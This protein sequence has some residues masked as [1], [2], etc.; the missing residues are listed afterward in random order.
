MTHTP[1]ADRCN[2]P[3]RRLTRD[4]DRRQRTNLPARHRSCVRRSSIDYVAIAQRALRTE[5]QRV[6]HLTCRGRGSGQNTE[7]LL[8]AAR[9]VADL[10]LI[11][12]NGR[13]LITLPDWHGRRGHGE[14]GRPGERKSD[15]QF[16]SA[17]P[18]Q[19]GQ[20]KSQYPR[21]DYG[22]TD[23]RMRVRR[24]KTAEHDDGRRGN[25]FGLPPRHTSRQHRNV[26]GS[27]RQ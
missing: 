11:P 22:R 6:S 10:K 26:R 2:G 27:S 18:G 19:D 25:L 23:V 9:A 4:R 1:R 20:R 13:V 24:G 16:V 8:V 5:R 12:N 3:G 21:C 15:R 14:A 7:N 17:L